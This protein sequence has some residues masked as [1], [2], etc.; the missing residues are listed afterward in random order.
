[1]RQAL[2]RSSL[3]VE[4]AAAREPSLPPDSFPPSIDSSSS[5]A[6][7]PAEAR[8]VMEREPAKYSQ[9]GGF[10]F[11]ATTRNYSLALAEVERGMASRGEAWSSAR[12][13]HPST[14]D[15]RTRRLRSL[16]RS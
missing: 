15:R 11:H 6:A 9:M 7:S 2:T 3:P 12:L 16:Q 13:A 4:E 1:M 10:I 5:W 8:T 14:W